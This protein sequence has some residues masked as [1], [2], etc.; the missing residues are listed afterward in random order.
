MSVES[1][2]KWAADRV[3]EW[4]I[5]DLIPY[6][7]NARKHSD[8]QVKQLAES[9]ERFGFTI[10]ILAAED[11]TIIAGHGRVMAAK[12]LGYTT[13]PVMV[14]RGWTDE[15]RRAYTL[16]DNR[17]AENATWDDDLLR[18]ELVWLREAGMDATFL[19]FSEHE[20]D[21]IFNGWE[22]SQK[23]IDAVDTDAAGDG[24][25]YAQIKVKCL[26]A[27]KAGVIEALK[28]ALATSGYEGVTVE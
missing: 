26:Q 9:M 13:V 8:A 24:E 7:Q 19:G 18:V 14:A 6:A 22:A 11:G 1:R 25:L 17:L 21:T 20:I 12:A 23:K 16:A 3:E 5:D 4:S 27:D 28:D 15:Q 10:P 2:G